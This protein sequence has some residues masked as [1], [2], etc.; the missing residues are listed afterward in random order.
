MFDK[1]ETDAPKKNYTCYVNGRPLTAT[2]AI[3]LSEAKAI[4]KLVKN[5]TGE[6]NASDWEFAKLLWFVKNAIVEDGEYEYTIWEALEYDSFQRYVREEL[7]MTPAKAYRFTR[8][9]E[10]F[11]IEL[12]HKFDVSKHLTEI[13]K[14][15]IIARV[16]TEKD[17]ERLIRSSHKCT[18]RQL[19]NMVA[20]KLGFNR[21]FM[22]FTYPRKNDKWRREAFRLARQMYGK[23]SQSELFILIMQNFVESN[24]SRR[25]RAA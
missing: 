8:A 12:G 18:Q 4:T 16:A 1:S 17:F 3:T 9:Y 6:K 20:G 2:K 24:S 25:R 14:L 15:S 10:K 13:E 22:S 19:K 11:G 5:A 23:D 21:A 7:N